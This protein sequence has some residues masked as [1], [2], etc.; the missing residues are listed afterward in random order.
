MLGFILVLNLVLSWTQILAMIG[1]FA[2]GAGGMQLYRRAEHGPRSRNSLP[3]IVLVG[4]AA[5]FVA[6]AIIRQLV[7]GA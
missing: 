5:F 4:G 6:I 2:A 3:D 1:A 7:A